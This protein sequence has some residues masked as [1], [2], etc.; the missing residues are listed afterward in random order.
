[1]AIVEEQPGT[2]IGDVETG[3]KEAGM[4]KK[5]T[6]GNPGG[7]T[8]TQDSILPFTSGQQP[9]PTRPSTGTLAS[10]EAMEMHAFTSP[11]LAITMAQI[12]EATANN[13]DNG[14]TNEEKAQLDAYKGVMWGLHKVSHILSEGYQWP[15]AGPS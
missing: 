6:G 4:G 8:D 2:T 5:D 1:M 15:C 7:P 3:P 13:G 9:G 14:D 10:A 11:A 12:Q